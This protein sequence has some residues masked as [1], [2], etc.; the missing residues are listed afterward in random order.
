MPLHVTSQPSKRPLYEEAY[1]LYL[2]EALSLPQIAQRVGLRPEVLVQRATNQNWAGRKALLATQTASTTTETR[3]AAQAAVDE[4]LVTATVKQ[5]NGYVAQLEKLKV[6]IFS[7]IVEPDADVPRG[8]KNY[9]VDL[10]SRVERKLELM[11]KAAKCFR[12]VVESAAG[13]G[14]VKI[15]EKR[16]GEG[17]KLDLGKLAQLNVAILAVTQEHEKAPDLQSGAIELEEDVV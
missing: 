1:R 7:L 4:N 3:I 10:A 5:V 17:G 14:L 8:T 15:A 13:I 9:F 16:D 2:D 6:S 11:T 12:E